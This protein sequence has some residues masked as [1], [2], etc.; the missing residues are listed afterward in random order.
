MFLPGEKKKKKRREIS[1]ICVV[2][3]YRFLFSLFLV[4]KEGGKK[5]KNPP[6]IFI[7]HLARLLSSPGKWFLQQTHLG[8]FTP[9][10]DVSCQILS[11]IA[12]RIVQNS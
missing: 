8:N 2:D 12:M 10:P 9:I 6:Q 7:R 5:K 11:Q 3:A 1:H 4:L